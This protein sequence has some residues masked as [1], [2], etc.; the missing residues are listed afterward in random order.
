MHCRLDFFRYSKPGNDF[1]YL[2][3]IRQGPEL[4]V[5]SVAGQE[6]SES[7]RDR[8]LCRANVAAATIP[9]A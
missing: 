2:Y 1:G 9:T 6:H 5:S 3:S 4:S 8:F 7:C